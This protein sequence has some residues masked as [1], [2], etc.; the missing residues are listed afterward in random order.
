[1]PPRLGKLPRSLETDQREGEKGAGRDAW[2][3]CPEG[4]SALDREGEGKRACCTEI[5]DEAPAV[6]LGRGT[7]LL[8]ESA[9]LS[10]QGTGSEYSGR[11][12]FPVLL[13]QPC[14][15]CLEETGT[16]G[17][18]HSAGPASWGPGHA[19]LETAWGP[20]PTLSSCRWKK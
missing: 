14:S 5:T 20:G 6:R 13:R 15:W 16:T 19:T 10:S 12:R 4:A 7:V 3:R 1:M 17:H 8:N 11:E 9:G 18:S 2:G